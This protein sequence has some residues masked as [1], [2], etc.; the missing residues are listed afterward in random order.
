MTLEE[1]VGQKLVLG[2][3][4]P[5]VTS[6]AVTHFRKTHAGGL[7]LF[8]RNFESTGQL[9]R[10]ISDLEGQLGRRLLVLVDHEGGRVLRFK[11]GVTIFPDPQALGASGRVEWARGQGEIEGEELRSVGIDVNLAPV[12]DVLSGGWNPAIGTRSYGEDPGLAGLLGRAR[13]EGMQSKGLSACA[14]HYPGLGEAERD[15]HTE[16]P[17]IRKSLKGLKETHLPP[18]LSAFQARVDCVMSSHPAYPEIE[19]DP[20]RPATFS[21]KI[22]HDLLRLEF[23]FT[24]VALTDDLKMGAVSQSVSLREGAPLAVRAGHDLLLVCS[25]PKA[26][27]EAF[28]ALLWAFKKKELSLK[29]LEESVERIG[30][31]KEKRK[32]RFASPTVT[33]RGKGLAR[34]IARGGTRVLRDGGG[35]LPLS[36]AWCLKHSVLTLFPDLTG[37][38]RERFIE[39]EL[40]PPSEFLKK[41][42]SRFGAPPQSIKTFSS[43]PSEE[44]R[45]AIGELARGEDL[46]L[47]FLWDAHLFTGAREL[48]KTLQESA[49]RLVVLLLRE[50][51]DL[52]W[53]GT[54]AACLTAYGFRTCQVEALIEKLFSPD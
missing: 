6:E 2:I 26:Q 25:D 36:S 46:V 50:P 48:L 14:K 28:E 45:L 37:V 11:E 4:G 19:R 24:G 29:E 3:E 20:R 35:L 33:N 47:F 7:V 17:V 52:K 39:P 27:E 15:P 44:E 23:G 34:E 8:E 21:R 32:V 13:I 42:F 12:L 43:D 9:K 54:K 22:I 18:F 38:A 53:V 49:K 5:R 1:L 40:L 31:L 16:L 41:T 30:R 10:L 51:S